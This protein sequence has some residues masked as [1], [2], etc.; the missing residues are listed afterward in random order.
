MKLLDK[1]TFGKYKGKTLKY[2][3][4]NHGTYVV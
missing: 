2:V 4:Q 1:F 3:L